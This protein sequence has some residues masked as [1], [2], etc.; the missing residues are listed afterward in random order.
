MSKPLTPN[1]V[2]GVGRLAPYTLQF[3]KH[4][5]GTEFRHNA[6]MIDLSPTLD[7][8][9][10][11]QE[12]LTAISLDF[13]PVIPSATASTLGLITL[14][15]DLNGIGSTAL[16]PKVGG[17]QGRPVQNITPTAGQVLAWSG[18][19]WGPANATITFATDLSG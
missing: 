15:G 5:N 14:G 19:F 18:S 16:A 2:P 6:T 1:Y 11:V 17:L 4:V 9:T 7:G 12:F 10:T 3:E 13:P 8:Y